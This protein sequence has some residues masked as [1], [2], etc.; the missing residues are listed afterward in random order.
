MLQAHFNDNSEKGPKY[1][2]LKKNRKHL[3]FSLKNISAILKLVLK[4]TY[5]IFF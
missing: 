2:T 4:Y 1:F 3:Q 5:G